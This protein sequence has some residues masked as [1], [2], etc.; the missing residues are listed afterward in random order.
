M[1]AIEVLN[2]AYACLME[3][4]DGDARK[5]INAALNGRL[6]Q[7]GGILI[8]DPSLPASLQGQQ[9]PSWWT[10][11]HDPFAETFTAG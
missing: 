1:S 8:D 11:E 6:G 4:V 7:D 9:A 10:D 5:R 2:F 3:G